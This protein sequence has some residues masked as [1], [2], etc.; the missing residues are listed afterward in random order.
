LASTAFAPDAKEGQAE[1]I[2]VDSRQSAR[3]ASSWVQD[4]WSSILGMGPKS[5]NP[6]GETGLH[7]I[8]RVDIVIP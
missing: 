3:P 6:P 7:W 4:E 2:R 8:G 1:R 5:H